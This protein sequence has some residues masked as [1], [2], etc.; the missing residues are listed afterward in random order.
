M[1][2]RAPPR[3]KLAAK[4]VDPLGLRENAHL[5][6]EVVGLPREMHTLRKRRHVQPPKQVT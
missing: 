6:P 4:A 3:K 1:G 5:P 2:A